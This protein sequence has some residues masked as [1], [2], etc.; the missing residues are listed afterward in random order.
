MK[1]S[2]ILGGKKSFPLDL[3]FAHF[4]QHYNFVRRFIPDVAELLKPLTSM[5]K[6]NVPFSW[7]KDGKRSFELIKEALAATPTLLHPYFSKDFIFDAYDSID[8]ISAML[9]REN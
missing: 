5:L 2:S 9:V 8:C 1:L 7:S 3:S 4:S 6:K